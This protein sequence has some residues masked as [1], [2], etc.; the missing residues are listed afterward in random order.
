MDATKNENATT[1]RRQRFDNG[2]DLTQR[3][4]GVQLRFDI[5]VA[6]QQFQIGDRFETDHLVAAGRV[7]D[8]VAG[9]REQIGAARRH[10]FPIIGGIGPCHDFRAHILQLMG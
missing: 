4:A 5:I 1:L 8:E 7:D 3:F 10:I 9:D 2:F 6:A